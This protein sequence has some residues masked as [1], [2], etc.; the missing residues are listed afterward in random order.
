MEN[1]QCKFPRG[2]VIGGC[3]V[4]NYMIYTRG[5]WRDYDNWAKL[6]NTGNPYGFINFLI[7]PTK[8][9]ET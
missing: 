7:S 4:L 1:H 2:K 8:N 3:S 5:N 9:F 6:G